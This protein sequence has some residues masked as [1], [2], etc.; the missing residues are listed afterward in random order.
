MIKVNLSKEGWVEVSEY[1]DLTP[2]TEVKRFD[3]PLKVHMSKKKKR[4][5]ATSLLKTRP[6]M[7]PKVQQFPAN[8]YGYMLSYTV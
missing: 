2:F 1:A 7:A 5:L 6:L 8:H 3:D 4:I